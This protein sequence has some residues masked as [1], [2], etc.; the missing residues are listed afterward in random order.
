MT[1]EFEFALRLNQ[2]LCRTRWGRVGVDGQNKL[3]SFSNAGAAKV[4][5]SC[6]FRW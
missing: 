4:G 5:G 2:L 3:D 6:T 1:V